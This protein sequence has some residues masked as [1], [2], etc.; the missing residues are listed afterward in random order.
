MVLIQTSKIKTITITLISLQFL[1]LA[2]IF[3]IPVFGNGLSDYNNNNKSINENVKSLSKTEFFSNNNTMTTV[4]PF[5]NQST[6]P[7][8]EKITN[9][10]SWAPY[11]IPLES[12]KNIAEQKNVINAILKQ[13]YNEYYFP[14]IDFKSKAT[15]SMTE[16]LLQ[17]ANGTKLKIIIILLPPSEAGPKGNFNWN[18]WIEYLNFL[19]TKYPSSLDGFVIDDFNLFNNSV[20]ANKVKGNNHDDSHSHSDAHDKNENK[21][22]KTPK[23]TVTFMLKS[24]LEEAL[25]KR[26][27]DLHFYPV[28]Y[29]EGVKTNDVK[30]HFYNNTDGIILAS[31]NYYNVTDLDHNLKVLSK[32]FNNKPIRYV[33]Y[34]DRTSNFIDSSPPSDRLVLSTLSIANESGIVKGVIIWRN[35]NSPVIRDY[36][37][38]RNNTEYMSL[39][40]MMEKLQ[41]K[42]ENSSNV[43]GLY[44]PPPPPICPTKQ[45]EQQQNSS[46]NHHNNDKHKNEKNNSDHNNNVKLSSS[47]PSSSI[48]PTPRLGISTSDLTPSLAEDMGLPKKTKGAAVQSVILGSPAYN[49]GLK[50]TILDVDESG[51]LIRRGDVIISV[52]G[53]KVNGVEDMVE[54][55]KKK[56]LGDLLSLIVSR[57]GQILNMVAKL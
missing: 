46:T 31:T 17:S 9:F 7:A 3:I 35:T 44:N 30:R 22:K 48:P 54:Q 39:V 36:L 16:N 51:Y 15:R 33:V 4:V 37:S 53:H 11:Q 10:G 21:N 56:H 20:H 50:G 32:V 47:Q 29:F 41:L 57:N 45:Q 40:S 49:A 27:K 28:L 8:I 14:M 25:Q 26:R 23:E 34:T 5:T 52:D 43:Y 18:S 19:K 24:K 2:S 38:N 12:I 1:L 6:M 13:G 42:D 55:M